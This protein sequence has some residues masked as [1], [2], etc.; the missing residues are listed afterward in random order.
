MIKELINKVADKAPE[1]RFTG[2]LFNLFPE[3]LEFPPLSENLRINYTLTP[4]AKSWYFMYKGKP[5]NFY[6]I[7][8]VLTSIRTG[9][10]YQSI[11]YKLNLKQSAEAAKTNYLTI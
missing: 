6:P 1:Y 11:S 3:L 10:R 8:L 5:F 7:W 2:N 9:L 4:I